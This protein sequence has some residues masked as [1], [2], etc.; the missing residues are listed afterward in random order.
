MQRLLSIVLVLMMTSWCAAQQT[1]QVPRQVTDRVSASEPTCLPAYMTEE[2]KLLPMPQVS[3]EAHVDRAPPTGEIH[4]AAEYEPNAGILFAWE[5]YTDLLTD[6]TV[7]ITTNDP[8]AIVHI[9]VDTSSEQTTAYNTL[10]SAGADMS[11]VDFVIRTTDTVWIRDYGPRYI[12]EDGERA[13]IDHTY[14][15]PRPNDN[16]LNDYLSVLWGEAEYDI[17]LTHGGG[18]FHLF[19]NGDAFM[20][21]LITDE[22]PGLSEQDVIDLYAEYQNLDLTIYP[23]FPGSFDGTGHIDM[24]MLPVGDDKIII[25]QYQP[26]DGTPY[27][28]TENAVDDLE[29]RGYTVYRIPGWNSGGTHYTYTNAVIFND[30]VFIS[31]F[32]HANDATALSVFQT[33]MP[34]H[35][36]IPLDCSSIIHAAGALHCI[37]MHRPAPP[38]I[39]L[40]LTLPDGAPSIVEPD[41]ATPITVSI[42]DGAESYVPGSGLIHYRFDGGTF[43]TDPVTPLGGNLYEATLPAADCDST[44]EF[45]F[46]ATG[47]GGTT[48]YNPEDAPVSLYTALVGTLTVI[49]EDDFETDQGW[50]VENDPSLTGGAWERG[51]PVDEPDE[52]RHPPRVDYDG[53]GQ[54]YLTQNVAGNSDVDYG[55]TRLIS[56][57]FDL[58]DTTEPILRFAYWWW[59]DDQDSDPMQVDISNDDGATWFPVQTIA[60][61]PSEWF[62]QDIY[63][64][65]AI[66][67]EP[68]TA[69]MKVRISV[70][71]TPNNSKDEAGIDAVQ[72]FDF[73]CGSQPFCATL[74]DP[75]VCYGDANGDGNV[76]TL[77]V[78]LIEA[79]YGSSDAESLCKFDINCDDVINTIDVG[80]TE[81]AYGACTAESADPCWAE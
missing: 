19:A 58:S 18:N 63:V 64:A 62:Q 45:Y 10:N 26:S 8:D 36:I 66:D 70:S 16:L 69:L 59:N 22:N 40:T 47:D 74:P 24:W 65:S 39:A 28:I 52:A 23:A 79:A 25:G 7:G 9:V 57:T 21:D 48:V 4:C 27:T 12:L 72:V 60:N 43:L 2:E 49:L 17:P 41:L 34:D 51:V 44:P 71:D 3:R 53:S 38:S 15:R 42:E 68:L 54:C 14:N 35:T 73:E 20:T 81:A 30:L 31:E 77:D 5:S 6:M 56:P 11:Q 76:N 32:N 37:S 1:T 80:L 75:A 61:V 50:T 29:S 46:S 13:I 67:P 78:G 55:P 33:A